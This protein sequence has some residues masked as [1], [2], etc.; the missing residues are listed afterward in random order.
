VAVGDAVAPGAG[1]AAGDSSSSL[2]GVAEG[3]ETG[4][5][6]AVGAAAV[7][8]GALGF[9][10]AAG[11]W[12]LAGVATFA[13]AGAAATGAGTITVFVTRTTQTFF[14]SFEPGA[15]LAKVTGAAVAVALAG[16]TVVG[17]AADADDE[18]PP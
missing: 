15:H 12:V 11:F 18:T 10:T 1:A 9:A 5:G 8:A 6:R 16:L 4:L 17:P 7:G 14:S 13:L 3:V 2:G